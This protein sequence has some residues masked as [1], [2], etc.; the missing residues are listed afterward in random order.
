MFLNV[1]EEYE[2]PEIL[3]SVHKPSSSSCSGLRAV[4]VQEHDMQHRYFSVPNLPKSVAELQ[5]AFAE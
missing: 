5:V 2:G 4:F 1:E 3:Y